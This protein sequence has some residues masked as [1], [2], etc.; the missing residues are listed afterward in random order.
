MS[1]ILD[2][3]NRADQERNEENNTPILHKNYSPSVSASNP[4]RRWIFEALIIILVVAVLV[5][6]Q[7]SQN[8][9]IQSDQPTID[10]DIATNIRT[11]TVKPLSAD[12]NAKIDTT[13][14]TPIAII[15]NVMDTENNELN[16]VTQTKPLPITKKSENSSIKNLYQKNILVSS[17]TTVTEKPTTF[18]DKP[19]VKKPAHPEPVDITQQVLQKIPLLSEYS[20]RF[21]QTVPNIDY[22]M[23]V[24]SEKNAGGFVNLNGSIRKIGA[25][26]VPGLRVIAILKDSVVLDYKGN[27]FRLAALNSW[28]NFN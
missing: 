21:Q 13:T 5:Y 16:I 20:S 28:A 8:T 7:W 3:L 9:P 22:S 25:E 23:H 18:V 24:Y 12:I 11:T 4:V 6:S 10:S 14:T 15:T 17:K 19:V 1:L 27:Q 26:V 2:A